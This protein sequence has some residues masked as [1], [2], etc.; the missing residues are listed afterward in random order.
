MSYTIFSKT[1][2]W[3]WDMDTVFI[4]SFLLYILPHHSMLHTIVQFSE[5][6]ANVILALNTHDW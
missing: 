5:T 1:M 6:E 2:T 3:I 4:T